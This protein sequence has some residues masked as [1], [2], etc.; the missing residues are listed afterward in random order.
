[1]AAMDTAEA[2]DR[3]RAE[4]LAPSTWGNGPHDRYGAHAH[5]YDKAIVVVA[6]SIRFGL[7]DRDGAIELAEGDRL[8][9][10]ADTRHDAI[11][12]PRGVTCLEAHL[13]AGAFAEPARRERGTW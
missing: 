4:G 9:L 12:G 10:P 11:V 3:L 2:T 8:E 1:M 6:G 7:P 5:D 13:A